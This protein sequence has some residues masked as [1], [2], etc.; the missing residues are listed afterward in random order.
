MP[1]HLL[2][3]ITPF[4]LTSSRSDAPRVGCSHSSWPHPEDEMVISLRSRSFSICWY[5]K[6]Y[7]FSPNLPKLF[8]V[9]GTHTW[10]ISSPSEI[11]DEPFYLQDGIQIGGPAALKLEML[12]NH[13]LRLWDHMTPPG[14][15]NWTSC[16]QVPRLK[17]KSSQRSNGNPRMLQVINQ[18]TRLDSHSTSTYIAPRLRR[19][20]YMRGH[21]PK[22]FFS[23]HRATSK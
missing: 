22:H 18:F 1:Y 8:Q 20:E 21:I 2:R 14:H 9:S 4:Q 16:C 12:E 5:V 23:V 7:C 10:G 13:A 19:Y 17:V 3:K 11:G 15:E 6:M